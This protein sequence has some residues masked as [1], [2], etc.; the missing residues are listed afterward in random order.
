MVFCFN[1]PIKFSVLK[2]YGT[3]SDTILGRMG[4]GYHS[5]PAIYEEGNYILNEDFRLKVKKFENF[6]L[7]NIHHTLEPIY[8]LLNGKCHKL[9]FNHSMKGRLIHK[10][11]NCTLSH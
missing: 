6:Y 7:K 10:L 4:G 1:P 2:K 11:N 3:S 8:T 9:T 5:T